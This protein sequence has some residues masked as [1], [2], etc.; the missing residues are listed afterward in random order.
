M[1]HQS[2]HN[3]RGLMSFD[4]F[5]H[6]VDLN[7]D[8]LVRSRTRVCPMIRGES[9]LNPSFLDM[10]DYGASQGIRWFTLDTN[11]NVKLDVKRFLGCAIPSVRVNIGGTNRDVHERV[12]R[13]SS[14]DLVTENLRGI[15]RGNLGRKKIILK[16][17]VTKDNFH[18]I[19]E[20]PTFFRG[21]GGNPR[22]VEIG[23]LQMITPEE[24]LP[25]QREDFLKNAVSSD[26]RDYML[27]D[28][29]PNG[30]VRSRVPGCRYMSPSIRWDG[31]VSI[32]CQDKLGF[33]DLANAF[34]TPF[35]EILKSKVF[36]T[37]TAK[38]YRREH[39]LC[40]ECN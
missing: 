38:G 21:L 11:L 29:G 19:P 39:T 33:F 28:V 23:P 15:L 3:D 8:Y 36:K 32:C 17:V 37:A 16:M 25:Q 1:I 27:F 4:N 12:M 14:F 9:F 26:T 30:G 5:K 31:S 34:E 6:W 2:P 13:G 35:D 18:Q 22:N 40:R 20:L 10:V 24:V 7:K